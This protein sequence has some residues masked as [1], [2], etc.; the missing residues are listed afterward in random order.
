[1]S[2]GYEDVKRLSE[3]YYWDM[4]KTGLRRGVLNILPPVE[5]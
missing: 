2:F 1:M 4:F 5:P 3:T